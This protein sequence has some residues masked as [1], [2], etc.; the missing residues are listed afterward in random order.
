MPNYFI[1]VM[2]KKNSSN[3]GK[4]L[5]GDSR[6]PDLLLNDPDQEVDFTDEGEK[7]YEL[8]VKT[9]SFTF[10]VGFVRLKEI[11]ATYT[12]ATD[13]SVITGVINEDAGENSWVDGFNSDRDS[14]IK[15]ERVRIDRMSGVEKYFNKAMLF[16]RGTG[17]KK[18]SE[19]KILGLV[20][21]RGRR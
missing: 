10:D 11:I 19:V 3:S 7:D 1:S 21:N 5:L 9:K 20:K 12:K 2:E 15:T 17:L 16:F 14:G 13:K 6:L 8:Q 18:I 4:I